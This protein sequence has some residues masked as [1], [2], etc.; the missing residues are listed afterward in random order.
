M[1][2]RGA[3]RHGFGFSA[4]LSLAQWT[5]MST[6]AHALSDEEAYK[7]AYPKQWQPF[8]EAILQQAAMRLASRPYQP[9]ADTV[10]DALKK[11]DYDDFRAVSYK[12]AQAIWRRE[13]LAFNLELFHS[14]YLYREP[15]QIFVVEGARAGEFRYQP[16]LFN[17]GAQV[18]RPAANTNPGFSG[19]R[20]HAPIRPNA[21][22]EEFVVFQGASY[23][24][25]KAA[26]QDYGQS[27][28]GLAINTGLP[29]P[30]EFPIFRSFW[31]VRPA[32]G[33]KT[34]TVHGLLD[35]VSVA[36]VYKFVIANT[37]DTVMDVTATLFPR[38]TLA[39]A[40]IAPL[41]SMFQYAPSAHRRFDDARQRVHDSDGLAIVNGAGEHLWRP[42]SNPQRLQTSQFRDAGVKGFGLL[43]RER[44]L[45]RYEDL[46]VPYELRPSLWVEPVGDW[47]AG[48]VDL[49][50]IPTENEY[51][52]NMVAFWH[53]AAPLEAGRSYSYS[54]KMTWCFE[55]PIAKDRAIVSQ[56]LVGISARHREMRFFNVDFTLSPAL[57][58][59]LKSTNSQL[60][61]SRHADF[62]ASSGAIVNVGLRRAGAAGGYR[63]GF[64]YLPDK[65]GATADLRC[66]LRAGGKPVSEV[67]IYHWSG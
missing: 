25:A 27:A 9:P 17:F 48:S 4:A 12:S 51:L 66:A 14:G 35:S 3:L 20:I 18:A 37:G 15:V 57:E 53:P 34:T 30:E 45:D 32:P 1:N 46:D 40:G 56:T 52:D 62:S 59:E 13:K 43:Q 28:R 64:E 24:R 33:E 42:L 47:G 6:P 41:T 39:R 29:E 31:I 61:W 21:G 16:D 2:R 58:Q 55:P 63:L 67:W 8:S 7:A 49:V 10:P 19:F 54:Y 65:G 26:G 11:W 50:E 36:G 22:E 38:K 44:R 23:L 60:D 5:L